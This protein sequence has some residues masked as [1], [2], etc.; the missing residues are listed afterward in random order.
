MIDINKFISNDTNIV[1]IYLTNPKMDNNAN[2]INIYISDSIIDRIKQKFKLT[3]EST[4]V[5]YNRNNL[6]YVYDLSNDSQYVFLRKLEYY[7]KTNYFYGIAFNEMKLQTYSFACTDD[8]DTR[9]EYKLLEFKINNRVS[10]LIKNNNV[11][12]TYKHSKDV[13]I[14]K[15]NEIVN[16]ITKKIKN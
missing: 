14:E 12:I 11:I 3:K 6:S 13:D 4:L 10:L 16:N 1:E 15:I 8:I 5:N 9:T 2:K 7:K